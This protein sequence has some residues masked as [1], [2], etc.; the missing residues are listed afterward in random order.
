[1]AGGA[2]EPAVADRSLHLPLRM[3][4]RQA[5]SARAGTQSRNRPASLSP[6]WVPDLR[7]AQ[8]RDDMT[9]P[10][11][12]WRGSV[13]FI[14]FRHSNGR[15]AAKSGKSHIGLA[16][17]PDTGFHQGQSAT[18]T[19]RHRG[20]GQQEGRP[21]A[22]A[23][24]HRGQA[25]LHGG[26]HGG[27]RLPRRL[28]RHRALSARAVSDHVRRAAVDHP[29]VRRLLDGGGFQRLLPAQHRRRTEGPV[30]RVR[31]R[32]PSRLRQRPSARARRRRH[33]GRGDR[34]PSTT[35]ARCST[36]STSAT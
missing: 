33:G 20:H 35:C 5:R 29:P 28:S 7:F 19:R 27:A 6:P 11:G 15:N 24:G 26:R 22:H 16:H 1:M 17:E 30:G 31:S 3:S 18:T 2:R 9:C 8:F 34:I 12:L 32:H 23:R 36:A 10:F 4:S 13:D 21:L 14:K 25:G